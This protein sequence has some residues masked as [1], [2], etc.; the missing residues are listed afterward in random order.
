MEE[1]PPNPSNSNLT[2]PP[3]PNPQTASLFFSIL[4]AE[5]RHMIYIESWRHDRV[6]PD[7]SPGDRP[8]SLKQHIV[9]RKNSN[10]F[11]HTPCVVSDQTAHDIRS[12][13]LAAFPPPSPHREIWSKRVEN[14][15]A[16][17]WPCEELMYSLHDSVRK[18]DVFLSTLLT[19]KLMYHDSHPLL[20]GT[21]T[22]VLTDIIT[23]TAFLSS[24]SPPLRSLELCIRIP[25][26]LPELYSPLQGLQNGPPP[27]LPHNFPF[28]RTDNP[29]S[30]LCL[31][32][33][34][35]SSNADHLRQ[36]IVWLDHKN[37]TPWGERIYERGFLAPLDG[38][39]VGRGRWR[40]ALP[41]VD[42]D[43]GKKRSSTERDLERRRVAKEYLAEGEVVGRPFVVVRGERPDYW[44]AHLSRVRAR[45]E[46]V[47]MIEGP[48][49][50]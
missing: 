39:R 3:P 42:D 17:H 8:S 12:D 11:T 20:Y 31:A 46:G 15:W 45:T 37:L 43:G 24:P 22:F 36:L 38:V 10:S 29:W 19:C 41:R 28:T 34:R 33:S 35:L 2:S 23:A 5:I 18:P 4:P 1:Q 6:H 27:S 26:I 16:V 50:V 44:E 14:E 30:R 40:L 32:L 7:S 25:P 48:P 47:L 13:K 21:L 9:K 49:G